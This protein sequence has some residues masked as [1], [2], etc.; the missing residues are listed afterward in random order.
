VEI[1]EHFQIKISNAALENLDD[2]SDMGINRDWE[3]LGIK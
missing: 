3:V 1:K 2:D